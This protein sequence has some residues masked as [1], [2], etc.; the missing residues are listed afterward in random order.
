MG[1]CNMS[2][3]RCTCTDRMSV[4]RVQRSDMY[5]QCRIKYLLKRKAVH[6]LSIAAKVYDIE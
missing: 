3:Q 5:K 1:H 2:V 6:G 4:Q